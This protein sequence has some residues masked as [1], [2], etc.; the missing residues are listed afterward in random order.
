MNIEA[1]WQKWIRSQLYDQVPC[2]IAIIDRNYRIVDHNQG[3][4][5]VFGEGRGF[6]CYQVYKGKLDRCPHCMAAHTFDDGR[7]RV[8]DE[9]GVDRL[10]RPAHYIV[11]IAPIYDKNGEISHV[12]EMSTDVTETKRLQ[13]E[14]QILF[15]RVPC[16]VAV[17]NRD[18]R[19]VRANERFRE[20]FGETT[21]QHCYEIFKRRSQKC[22]DC[23]AEQT[24]KDGQSHSGSHVGFSKDGLPTYYYVTT[25]ALSRGGPTFSPIMEMALDVTEVHKLKEELEQANAIRQTLIENSIDGVIA[26]DAAGKVI[27]FNPAARDML[28]YTDGELLGRKPPDSILPPKFKEA[29]A[30]G[31]EICILPEAT[32]TA[33]DGEEIPVRFSSVTLKKG[34][35][36]IG[37]AIFLQDLRKF[38]QLEREKIE[39]ERLAAVGQTVAGLAHGIKNILTGLEGGMYVVNSGLQKGQQDRIDVGWDM[40]KRNIS[41]I[42]TLVKNLLNFSK[43]RTPHVTMVNPN[44]IVRDILSLYQGAA[45]QDGITLVAELDDAVAPAPL[46]SEEIHT[47]L[48]NLVSNALDACKMSEKKVCRISIVCREENNCLVFEVAD[49][50]SGMDYEIK[51]KVFTNFFTTKGSGGTGMGLLLTRKIVQEHGGKITVESTP[52]EGSLFRLVFPRDRL[53]QPT[54]EEAGAQPF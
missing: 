25:T 4:A 18:Y 54:E 34:T 53:P 2:N 39:A 10:G 45:Q 46:D 17:L 40:L 48:A 33:N 37:T 31:K 22:E 20:T 11:H 12:I 42:S 8:N 35:E 43:G 21:G 27:I 5:E 41:K 19:V 1:E 13:R 36:P 15:E 51:Q 6:P 26:T 30:E 32:I 52:G 49:E 9:V 28:K 47:C 38:R 50:G 16:Y 7:V 3:F 29:I 44:D 24:F 14:Y 23:P